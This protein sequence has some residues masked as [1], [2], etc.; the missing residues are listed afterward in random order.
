MFCNSYSHYSCEFLPELAGAG[1][2]PAL[3]LA[4][5]RSAPAAVLLSLPQTYMVRP[6]QGHRRCTA[7]QN[8]CGW[9]RPL[10][11]SAEQHPRGLFCWAVSIRS[12][13]SVEPSWGCG[14]PNDIPSAM[15]TCC[16]HHKVVSG[17]HAAWPNPISPEDLTG[18]VCRGTV[19]LQS[20]CCCP[21]LCAGGA[22]GPGAG[23]R[24]SRQQ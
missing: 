10:R 2:W 15:S 17:H 4:G 8:P 3:W 9:K 11:P 13:P 20:G 16:A 6:E 7:S 18:F 1:Q 22:A 5:L 24:V 14:D 23:S 19:R 12:A 21:V